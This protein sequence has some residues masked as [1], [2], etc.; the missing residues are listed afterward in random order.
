MLVQA[1]QR[2]PLAPWPALI[3]SRPADGM[4]SASHVAGALDPDGD[5]GSVTLM[6]ST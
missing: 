6:A 5:S 3:R 2:G 4:R 1:Y